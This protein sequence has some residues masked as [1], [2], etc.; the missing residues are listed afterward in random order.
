MENIQAYTYSKGFNSVCLPKNDYNCTYYF[1]MNYG[2][3]AFLK[4]DLCL[5]DMLAH[6]DGCVI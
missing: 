5:N 2:K 6:L 1:S 3:E 4:C